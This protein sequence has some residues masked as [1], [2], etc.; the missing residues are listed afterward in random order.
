MKRVAIIVLAFLLSTLSTVFILQF[1]DTLDKDS[2]DV[3]SVAETRRLVTDKTEY[4]VGEPIMVT[5]W[6]PD[7]SDKIVLFSKDGLVALRWSYVGESYEDG[8]AVSGNGS[9]VPMDI[10]KGR[11]PGAAANSAYKNLPAGEYVVRL[12][13]KGEVNWPVQVY[14]TIK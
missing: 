5:V 2:A 3:I 11:I 4:E 1:D 7:L 13:R 12:E 8:A 6:T 10:T 14:I 9:G